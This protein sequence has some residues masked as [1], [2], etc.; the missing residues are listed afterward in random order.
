MGTAQSQ[1]AEA[2]QELVRLQSPT[3]QR[4]AA[5]QAH[6]E[7]EKEALRAQHARH[8][9]HGQAAQQDVAQT[10]EMPPLRASGTQ[11]STGE[12]PPQA[13][14]A[15]APVTREHGRA[16]MCFIGVVFLARRR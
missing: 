1:T 16:G 14:A 6:M 15:G 5:V 8:A 2:E 9:Q 7:E 13:V 12:V 3:D 11:G 4:A 10:P